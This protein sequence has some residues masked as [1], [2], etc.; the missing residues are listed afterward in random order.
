MG[1]TLRCP[2]G[3]LQRQ[4]DAAGLHRGYSPPQARGG[5]RLPSTGSPEG[6]P[7]PA[8]FPKAVPAGKCWRTQ[9]RPRTTAGHKRKIPLGWLCFIKSCVFPPRGSCRTPPLPGGRHSRHCACKLCC[10]GNLQSPAALA[11]QRHSGLG[12]HPGATKKVP[13]AKASPWPPRHG[14]ML[15]SS[16]PVLPSLSRGGGPMDR[17]LGHWMTM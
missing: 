13:T 6:G 5:T 11:L 12:S 1:K 3:S 16:L 9:A 10:Q 8:P 4:Q 7:A 15:A 17:D 2:R 14:H